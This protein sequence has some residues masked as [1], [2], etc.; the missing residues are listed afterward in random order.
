MADTAS[1]VDL[2]PLLSRTAMR[3]RQAFARLYDATAAQLFETILGTLKPGNGAQQALLDTYLEI[4]QC[5]R[6]YPSNDPPMAWLSA[7]AHARA[8]ALLRSKQGQ[9]V[10]ADAAGA[11]TNG[12]ETHQPPMSVWLAVE[13][14]LDADVEPQQDA[15]W[16][17][18]AL[19]RG[20]TL[21]AVLALLVALAI[22][23][24]QPAAPAPTPVYSLVMRGPDQPPQWLLVADWRLRIVRATRVAAAPTDR[25]YELWLLPRLGGGP[26][27]LGLLRGDAPVRALPDT[28]SWENVRAFAISLEPVGGS[29]TGAPSGSVLYAAEAPPGSGTTVP[30]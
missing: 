3:D 23:L 24:Q 14:Q 6:Q 10:G 8:T 20:L 28:V 17:S 15:W 30:L 5:A 9:D 16:Y 7:I 4:W 18:L 25:D 19:W 21:A 2:D 13:A 12:S 22:P 27:S 29:P 11:T 26:V 1:R